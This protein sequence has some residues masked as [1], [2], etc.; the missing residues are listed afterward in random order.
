MILLKKNYKLHTENKKGHN[1]I[2]KKIKFTIKI[3]LSN[4]NMAI[5][6]IDC[7]IF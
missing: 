7:P 3:D 4:Y 2:I 6:S 1:K 5:I